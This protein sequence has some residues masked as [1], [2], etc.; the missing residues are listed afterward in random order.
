[1]SDAR[2]L[3]PTDGDSHFDRRRF[4]GVLPVAA[5]A[6][7]NLRAADVSTQPTSSQGPL[8][9]I[10]VQLYTVREAMAR[11]VEGTLAAIAEIGYREV[12]LWRLHGLAAS[13]MGA[14]LDRLGL[15]AVSSHDSIE[16]IR[17]EWPRRLDEA[18]Q[19]GQSYLVC[20][21]IPRVERT[22]EGY[23]RI[24]DD[25]NEAGEAAGAMGMRLGYH[26]H[27]HEFRTID[28]VVPYDLLLERCDP[29]F[30]DMQADLFWMVH[31]GVDPLDYFATHPGRFSSVHVKDRTADGDMV[32]L[33]EG[34][35]DF[36]AIF[37]RSEQ[38]GI[39]HVFV[40][41]DRPNDPMESVRI[42]FDYLERLDES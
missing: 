30:V 32:D 11:D 9:A 36:A 27:D 1:M 24:T 40:E 39:R 25:F 12:E 34:V 28:G 14:L 13:E 18:A 26:N 29:Q 37:A 31:A 16:V 4:L 17:G 35:I 7:A 42:G 33:G 20:P 22:L 10:G 21:S 2:E 23:R 38:A 8:D 5:V 6:L 3:K 41:H 15:E 19:L